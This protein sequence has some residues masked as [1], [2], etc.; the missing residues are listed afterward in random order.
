ML[1]KE[2][3]YPRIYLQEVH[4]KYKA[5]NKLKCKRMEIGIQCYN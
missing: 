4:C 2:K 1:D 3:Q 5:I